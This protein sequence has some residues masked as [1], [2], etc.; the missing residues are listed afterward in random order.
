MKKFLLPLI[1]LV[2]A[3]ACT[4]DTAESSFAVVSSVSVV[5]AE[6]GIVSLS[7]NWNNCRYRLGTDATFVTLPTILYAGKTGA[8]GQYDFTVEFSANDSESSRTAVFTFTPVEGEGSGIVTVEL[9]QQGY[10]PV[11][12]KVTLS[13]STSYQSWDGFGAMNSWG[14]SDYWS[15][16]E[17]D[18]LMGTLGLDIMRIRIPVTEANWKNLVS[19]CKYAYENYGT[20][21]L[22]SPWTMPVSMKTP[23]QLEASKNG[24]TSSL[25]AECYEEYAL[26]L[27]KFA[28][29]MKSNG[30]PLY[31]ISVQNEPDWTATY[32]GCIWTSDEHLAFVRDYGHL[33]TSTRLVTGESLNFNHSFY[34]PVLNDATACENIDIVGG[35]LYGSSPQSYSLAR[36]KGKRIWMTEHLLNDSWKNNTSHW[37]ETMEMLSEIH[38]CLTSGFNAY[39][40][41]YGRRYYSFIG[42]GDE[43]TT[44][45]TILQR[46]KAYGQYS[47]HIRAGHV[48]VGVSAQNA[49]GLLASAFKTSDGSL[50]LVLVNTLKNAFASLEVD[51]GTNVASALASCTTESYSG[52]VSTSVSGSVITL[53][54]PASSVSTIEIK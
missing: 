17:I 28:S 35:H 37:E 21:I 13:P 8:S 27:E 48:R 1:L 54:I 16:S 47:S 36:E 5:P 30:A 33:V 20:R 24:V 6:G 26:Y 10:E 42:D 45:G 50:S 41:W 53:D 22:A 32:E 44:K 3:S 15:S 11:K 52:E 31:A 43:G 9:P 19:G 40:W 14:D 18:L 7:A 25:K 4:P 39:I 51:A 29:Y 23:E 2:L 38:G 12:A 34:D 49:D 46:G